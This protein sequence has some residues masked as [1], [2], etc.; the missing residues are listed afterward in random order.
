MF[1]GVVDNGDCTG[2]KG[3]EEDVQSGAYS[4]GNEVKQNA[5]NG[6][7]MS[8]CFS[9]REKLCTRQRTAVPLPMSM[10]RQDM[11]HT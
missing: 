9:P 3:Q 10:D 1:L 6:P 5:G 11:K 7:V 2:V 8:V 4:S